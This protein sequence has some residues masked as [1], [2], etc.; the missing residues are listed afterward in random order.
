[1]KTFNIRK[2]GDLHELGQSLL[3]QVEVKARRESYSN[4]SI[5]RIAR[6][7]LESLDCKLLYDPRLWADFIQSTSVPQGRHW[8]SDVPMVL[9]RNRNLYVEL[10][11]WMSG[12]TDIHAH[13]FCGAFRVIQGS[14]IHTPYHFKPKRWISDAL[15]LG[16]LIGR[17]PEYL[18]CGSVREIVPGHNGLIHSLFH[19]DAPS[20]TLLIRT[21]TSRAA[22]PQLAFYPPG[23]GIDDPGLEED[24]EI[25]QLTRLFAT[26][27]RADRRALEPL[28]LEALSRL[29]A[30]RLVKMCLTFSAR[31][32]SDD[33]RRR[34]IDM[35]TKRHDEE[36]ADWLGHV[37]RERVLQS[38]IR[39][40]RETVDDPEIRFFLGLLLNVR[41]RS[42][43]FELVNQRFP[44]CDPSRAC[45]EWL[46]GLSKLRA[47]A[48]AFMQEVAARSEGPG[49]RLGSLIANRLPEGA[50]AEQIQF[51]LRGGVGS[52]DSGS[53]R[54]PF[55]DLP[56][57][58]VLFRD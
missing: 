47:N 37:L 43:L 38:Q 45:A 46:L 56:E 42:A 36:L 52:D 1:M 51:W 32:A 12:T 9:A 39:A 54:N 4:S 49:Y 34:L 2:S 35:V 50:S 5:Q 8:F 48:A 57:L 3:G 18:G 10:L 40:S 41:D 28:M 6:E 44:D 23:L 53:L 17:G 26:T 58:S 29:D 16:Q 55:L 15:V 13:S 30:P 25:R 24:E 11:C 33:K 19:L 21:H 22:K 7:A 20:L 31:F 14:S 27:A